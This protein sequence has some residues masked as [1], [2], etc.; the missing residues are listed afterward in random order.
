[1][2]AIC[3]QTFCPSSCPNADEATP[4]YTC[5]YCG[6]D[7]VDGEEY[8]EIDGDYYHLYDCIENVTVELLLENGATKGVACGGDY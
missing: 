6:E 7:I 5:K 8:V 4:V 1:M 3:G 2:C